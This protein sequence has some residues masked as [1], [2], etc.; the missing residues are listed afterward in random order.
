LKYYY[1]KRLIDLSI[2]LINK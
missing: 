2:N 1:H